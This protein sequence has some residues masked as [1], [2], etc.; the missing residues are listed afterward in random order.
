MAVAP[1]ATEKHVLGGRTFLTIRES[2][3]EQDF[4][5]IALIKRARIDEI[6][7]EPGE[8]PGAFARRLL[9][10]AVESAAI[11]ELLGCLLVPEEAAPRDRDPGEA[12]TREMAEETAR[13]LGGLKKPEDKA[14]V[15]GLVLSL[16]IPFVESGIVSLRT[17]TTS[18]DGAVPDTRKREPSPGA[19]AP[20]P[21][22]SSSSPTETTSARSGSSAGLSGRL[23]TPTA[24]E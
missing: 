13:F 16:I 20:G 8:S 22:S 5:F 4:R 11:L 3:V 23:S 14:K 1:Q 17:S 2:T 9:E 21:G 6:T 10:A 12:W 15:H 18:S 24:S 19:T 7:L